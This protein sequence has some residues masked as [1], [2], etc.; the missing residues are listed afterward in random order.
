M[1]KNKMSHLFVCLAISLLA[2]Q[3]DK[4]DRSINLNLTE[5][6]N[7]FTPADNK[8]VLLKPAQNLTETFEWEQAKAEDGGLVLYEIAWD[9]QNG[10][11]SHP[12][13]TVTSDNKG[14]LNKLTI[15]HGD[16]NKIAELGGAAFFEKK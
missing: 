7:F 10:D 8:Y 15:S 1:F 5:V 16:L 11:F 9:Q 12:F 2:M 3:C 13:Y 14:V 4:N 6:S